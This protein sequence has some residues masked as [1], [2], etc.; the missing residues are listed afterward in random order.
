MKQPQKW[1]WKE[2]LKSSTKCGLVQIPALPSAPRGQV[3][4]LSG[5]QFTHL[6][7]VEF[8]LH[9]SF[10]QLQSFV[11]CLTIFTICE[12]HLQHSRVI[13]AFTHTPFYVIIIILKTNLNM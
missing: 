4:S 5:P 8:V 2:A 13:L 9:I 11:F 7:R 12:N 10:P 3:F 1:R 6:Q